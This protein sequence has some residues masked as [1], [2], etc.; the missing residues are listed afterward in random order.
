MFL[1]KAGDQGF[2]IMIASNSSTE[3]KDS[4]ESIEA[5]GNQAWTDESNYVYNYVCVGEIK[6]ETVH[7]S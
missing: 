5:E 7:E 3:L 2:I 4:E 1:C 6:R